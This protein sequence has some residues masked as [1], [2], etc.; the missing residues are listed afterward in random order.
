MIIESGD[1]SSL[2]MSLTCE[3][4]L[5]MSVMIQLRNVP[6]ALHRR[7]KARAALEGMSLSDY[8]IAEL[9]RFAERPTL[10]EMLDRLATR[11]PVKVDVS[12]V[13]LI[14]ADR[15]SR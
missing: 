11:E 13:D 3:H 5:H 6:D 1:E 14:R 8:C 15:D 12:I 2:D 10:N 4:V 9:R 7:L